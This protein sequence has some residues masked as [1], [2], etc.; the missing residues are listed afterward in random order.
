MQLPRL[1]ILLTL[2]ALTVLFL[3]AAYSVWLNDVP[4][5]L[6]ADA[7]SSPQPPVDATV[8]AEPGAEV[9]AVQLAVSA[10]GIAGVTARQLRTRGMPIDTLSQETLNLSYHGRPVPFLVAGAGENAT[11]YFY[12]E[13]ITSTLEGPAV[14]RLALN[15]AGL[16]MAQASAQP[17]GAGDPTAQ[18]TF[19][20]SENITFVEHAPGDDLW[21]GPLLFSGGTWSYTFDAIEPDGGTAELTVWLL[22]NTA[23]TANPGYELE[24]RVNG[25]VVANHAWSG[26][27]FE[28]V[29]IPLEAG[30]LRADRSNSVTINMPGAAE[31]VGS[32]VYIDA[33]RLAYSGPVVVAD[34]QVAF[35]STAENVTIQATDPTLMVFDVSDTAQP[36]LLTGLEVAGNQVSFAGTGT[37]YV[38]LGAEQVVQPAVDPLPNWSRALRDPQRRADYIAIV[39]AV[40]G[41]EAAI[42]PLLAYRQQQGLQTAS[43]ALEQIFDEFSYGQRTPQAIRDFLSYAAQH[44]APPAP[45]FV[46]LVGDAT[47][48][49]RSL[50]PGKNLNHVP[51]PLIPV[52]RSGYTAGDAWYT[53]AGDA[54]TRMAIGRFPA[55]EASE[56]ST[57]VKKTILYEQQT[58]G[59]AAW[60]Q[61]A[62]LVADDE[63]QFDLASTELANSLADNGYTVYH[64][65]MS[66][67]DNIHYDIMSTINRGIGLVNYTGDGGERMWG[68]EAVLE[69]ADAAL[70]QNGTRLPILTTF[71]CRNG[72]FADP[73]IDTLAE[74]LLRVDGGG[75]VAAIAPSGR[76]SAAQQL[77]LAGEFYAGLLDGEADTLGEALLALE[78][79][80]ADDATLRD[81]LPMVNLLG[82]PALRIERP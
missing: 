22:S 66:Q 15:E 41:F 31:N 18:Q 1:V 60:K 67:N 17:T 57:M 50:S 58:G 79:R 54:T 56:V 24:I 77:P 81:I 49:I 21:M 8:G 37:Q 29:R 23:T 62:L 61:R 27:R 34:S 20:W 59:D 75:V 46:L 7:A 10:S 73:R 43:I 74:S 28:E 53:T 76:G 70:L 9:Q 52:G 19:E 11:L 51:T 64:L 12:A 48:D 39:P 71:T 82:D 55:Q 16:A 13:A 5:P 4:Q 44:W 30:L 72:A 2:A 3:G 68:D 25:R 78:A 35:A 38:A 32:S 63:P 47:V 33:I 26:I 42:E 36:V 14:Y 40:P 45:Q 69:E 80:A 65:H 6:S